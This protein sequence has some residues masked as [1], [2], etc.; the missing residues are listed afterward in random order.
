MTQTYEPGEKRPKKRGEHWPLMLRDGL[1]TDTLHRFRRQ[2]MNKPNEKDSVGERTANS[3]ERNI[4]RFLDYLET[5]RNKAPLEANTSDLRQYLIH[6]KGQGDK[7]N[8]IKTRRSAVSRFYDEL[9]TLATDDVID[10]DASDVPENPEEGYSG[11]WTVD[12]THKEKVSG[13]E[14]EI[15]YLEPEEVERLAANVPAPTVRNQL[16]V[17]LL[18]QTGMRVSEFVN[19]KLRHVRRD[20]REIDVPAVTSKSNSRTVAYK[21]SLDSLL[22]RWIDG[23]HRD[24]EHYAAE[25]PYLIPTAQSEHISR[26]TVRKVIVDAAEN[27]GLDNSTIYVDNAGNKRHPINVHI[28]RHSMAVNSLSAGNLNV[29]ELQD[30]LGHSSLETTEKYLKIATESATDKYHATGGPPEGAD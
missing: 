19:I 22:R 30:I 16:I 12:E 14:E 23:G 27:A 28:L 26:E 3:Y 4:R 9:E 5:H 10:L 20:D 21:P 11:T 7:D 2:V 15:N 18:Y 13:G 25:S 24:A 8:T 29:R 17:R 1:P 6:C